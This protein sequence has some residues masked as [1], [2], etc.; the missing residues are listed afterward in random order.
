MA[1]VVVIGRE[2]LVLRE[3]VFQFS[4]KMAHGSH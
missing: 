4:V 3:A 2:S 1:L